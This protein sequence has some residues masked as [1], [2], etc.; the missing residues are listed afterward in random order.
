MVFVC[1]WPNCS[2]QFDDQQKYRDHLMYELLREQQQKA[3]ADDVKGATSQ[4][5]TMMVASK[6]DDKK[7][8]YVL[9]FVWIKS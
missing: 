4:Q 7:Q 6:V 5:Q 3:A 9:G 8:M 2:K 1:N